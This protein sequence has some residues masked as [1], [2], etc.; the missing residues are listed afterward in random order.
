MCTLSTV[1]I[2]KLMLSESMHN[3]KVPKCEILDLMDSRDFYTKKPP[4]VGDFGTVMKNL[5][6][7][8]FRHDFEVCTRENFALVH[9]ESALN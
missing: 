4:W 2:F 5:K 7:F 9:A 1:Q 6:L 8:R 3:L